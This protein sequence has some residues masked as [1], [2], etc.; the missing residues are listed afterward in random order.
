M[1]VSPL[2][3]QSSTQPKP[4]PQKPASKPAQPRSPA[5]T[6]TAP[7][8]AAPVA[9]VK[10]PATPPDV[11]FKSTYVTG[12]MKTEA[13]TYVKGERERFE[14]KDMV[15]LKQHDQKRTIQISKAANTYLVAPD[16][17]PAAP[18]VPG[19]PQDAASKPAGVIGV[20]T[21]IVDTGERKTAFGQQAR[22]VKT[23]IDKQPM[24][25]ACDTSK[26]RIETDAWYI[27]AP[28]AL[29]GQA[30]LSPDSA[31]AVPGACAD[32]IQAT[33]NGDAKALGF[34]IAYTTTITGDDGKPTVS[35]MEV[36]EFE[37]TTLDASLFEIP[38][39]L[40]AAMNVRELSK[41]LSDANEVKLAA[42]DAAATAAAPSPKTPGVVRIGVPEFTNKTPQTVDTRT[43][44][45][46]L[47]AD[48]AEAK[49]ETLPMAAAASADLQTRAGALGYD[50]VLLAEVSDL[51]VSKPGG[52]GG[53]MKAASDA[54]GRGAAPK[55]N[56]ES[57]IAVKLIQADGKQRLSTTV[58]GKNGAG[59]NLQTGLGLAK[60]AGGVYMSM[61]AAP[62]MM[63]KFGNLNALGAGNL[64]GMSLLGNP[65]LFQ[66]QAGGLAG[67]GK[68]AGLDPTAG[69]ASVLMQN[70][71]AMSSLGGLVGLPGQGPSYDESLGDAL[72][73]VTK[74]V[75]KALQK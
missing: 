75:Q 36:T 51:K 33:S 3:A 50:Y 15:L 62:L 54:V 69:A 49:F 60:M 14:F 11:R 30:A 9:E 23:I 10:P 64:G 28:K 43:L 44:R 59:F 32:R 37:A 34:P 38:P 7:A 40:N 56:T 41:A 61:M 16:G 21:T 52:I 45:Q 27:D 65:A 12:D 71:M 66:L 55:E 26:Q 63:A 42:D 17:V 2:G 25:G 73:N 13:V 8:P 18:I 20:T 58:K 24:A 35:A 6:K 57:S 22:H 5:P 48:L 53:L 1:A 72:L 29:S 19:A 74:A 4:L 70:T 68:G 46:R 31:A 47:I 39:G 67:L